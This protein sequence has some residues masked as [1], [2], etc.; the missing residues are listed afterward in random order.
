MTRTKMSVIA[1]ALV[2][3]ATTVALTSE[4]PAAADDKRKGTATCHKM[5]GEGKRQLLKCWENITYDEGR[6]QCYHGYNGNAYHHET[7]GPT[8]FAIINGDVSWP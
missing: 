2:A 5:L 8:C 4:R 1:L 7:N 3:A 6:H